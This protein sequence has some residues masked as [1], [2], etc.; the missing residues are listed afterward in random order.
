MA[1]EITNIHHAVW[2]EETT[3]RGD[4]W[5][6]IDLSGSR[7]GVRMEELAPGERSSLH[8]YH[9]IDEE[10]VILMEG[11]VTLCLG[12]DKTM[13]VAG[14]HICFP[15]GEPIAHHLRNES[16]DSAK[17][18]VFGERNE[19][20]VVFYPKHSVALVKAMSRQT[21]TFEKRTIHSQTQSNTDEKKS[22]EN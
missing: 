15:A 10:H 13:L 7:L 6:Y 14:D 1:H 8:H 11:S 2:T 18:V 20:D 17:Y 3:A 21:Y 12:E 4:V 19:G 16:D 9:T 22:T 5:R